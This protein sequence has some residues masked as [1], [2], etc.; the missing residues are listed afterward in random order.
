MEQGKL[1]SEGRDFFFPYDFS[2]A[3]QKY[4]SNNKEKT[5]EDEWDDELH[6]LICMNRSGAT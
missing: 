5:C 4:L 3:T 2:S 1:V 6:S